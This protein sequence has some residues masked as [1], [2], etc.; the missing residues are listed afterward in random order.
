MSCHVL[1]G[2][3]AVAHGEYDGGTTTHISHSCWMVNKNW[4]K[5]DLAYSLML[6]EIKI[7]YFFCISKKKRIFATKI[8]VIQQKIG[9]MIFP[10][11]KYLELLIE[12]EGNGLVKIV[13]GGR[14]CGKSF[15][16]FR[17]VL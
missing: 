10:R 6:S 16:L 5:N 12:S 11:T 2:A 7:D 4:Y 1:G 14:R 3:A 9:I 17:W 15:L 8:C 13:T